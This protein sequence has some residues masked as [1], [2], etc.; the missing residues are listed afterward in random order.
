MATAPFYTG[1]AGGGPPN[2][3]SYGYSPYFQGNRGKKT[4]GFNNTDDPA[5]MFQ[6]ERARATEMGDL[7]EQE[8]GDEQDFWRN[9]ERGAT[10]RVEGQYDPIWR[11]GGGYNEDETRRIQGD[12]GLAGLNM[13]DDERRDAYLRGDEEAAMMGDPNKAAGFYDP[14]YLEDTNFES[15]ARQRGQFEE[16]KQNLRGGVDRLRSGY[17]AAIDPSRLR[18]SEDYG[19]RLRGQVDQG[20]SGMRGAAYDPSL[21]VSDRYMDKRGVSDAEVRQMETLGGMDAGAGYQ[22]AIDEMERSAAASGST[23]PLAVAA[24]RGELERGAGAASTAAALRARIAAR[25]SQRSGEQAIEDTRLGAAGTRTG[26]RLDA[27]DRISGRGMEAERDIEST[28]MGGE[29]DVSDRQMRAAEGV[30]DADLGAER[31][32]YSGGVDLERGIGDRTMDVRDRNQTRGIELQQGIDD[33]SVDRA[34]R[35]ATNRQ[36]TSQGLTA[37]RFNRGY[38]INQATSERGRAVGDARR[39]D[40]A[41]GRQAAMNLAQYGGGRSNQTAQNR[42]GFYGQT[43]QNTLGAAQGAAGYKTANP[44]FGRTLTQGLA[45]APGKIIASA[46]SK[47]LGG[48]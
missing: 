17:G 26:Y 37:D 10:G 31:D 16:G 46:G 45:S 30:G 14:G 40:Q 39:Q 28:R 36:A 35:V 25:D 7:Y 38:Q 41:E 47:F 48:G 32:I 11:G 19:G 18:M 8:F 6:N 21:N 29:R 43:S 13:T 44:S 12:E 22:S 34:G 33:R 3:G 9:Y 23:N 24:M 20:A 15:A 4:I 42:L 5:K 1:S 27:E 2:V